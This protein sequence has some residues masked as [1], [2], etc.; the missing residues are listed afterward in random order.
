MIVFSIW[1]FFTFIG[2]H[3]KEALDIDQLWLPYS[4]TWFA[5]WHTGVFLYQGSQ[6]TWVVTNMG[7]S[8]LCLHPGIIISS[9]SLVLISSHHF[10]QVTWQV[11]DQVHFIDHLKVIPLGTIP[12]PLQPL[13]VPISRN[14]SSIICH[15]TFLSLRV[16]EI[17]HA[18]LYLP[19]HFKKENSISKSFFSYSALDTWIRGLKGW[20]T[21]L[22]LN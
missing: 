15:R 14:L 3:N 17:F 1:T 8:G 18:S 13:T 16:N 20:T 7:S 6:P 12:D 19:P 5:S 22:Y 21:L 2:N 11:S 9:Y 4:F 10:C